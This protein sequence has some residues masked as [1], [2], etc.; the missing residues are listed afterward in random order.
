LEGNNRGPMK[1]LAQYLPGETDENQDSLW[2]RRYS[3]DAPP[4]YQAKA[5]QLSVH[6]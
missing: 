5:L 4:Q 6:V 3:N 2:S 1:V